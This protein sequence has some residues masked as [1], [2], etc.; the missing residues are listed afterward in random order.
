MLNSD[1]K[2]EFNR[3]EKRAKK[4]LQNKSNDFLNGSES[5]P[6]YLRPPYLFYEKSI[7]QL[8]KSSDNI[9][10]IGSGVGLH[11]HSLLKTG[12]NVIASDI[13]K[14]SLEVLEQRFSKASNLQTV[15]ADIENLPFSDNTFS[16]VICAGSLSYGKEVLVDSEIRR[17][18]VPRGKFICVDSLNNNPI[19]RI[20]RYFHYRKFERSK[21]TLENMPTVKRIKKLKKHFHI[22]ELRFYGSISYLMPLIS[23]LSNDKIAKKISNFIDKIFKIKC[24]AF[25]FVLVAELKNNNE[26]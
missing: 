5:M 22:R 15:V 6:E 4:L 13:S 1:K 12:S 14:K 7:H 3:F 9:L 19:Y 26:K 18:L 10:E 25:K 23:K 20:N 21:M 2:I 24:S 8:I 11:T 17:V 16:V